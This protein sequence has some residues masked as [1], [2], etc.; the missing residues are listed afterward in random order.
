MAV[1]DLRHRHAGACTS[2]T[3]S[4]SAKLP[5][6]EARIVMLSRTQA[7]LLPLW[8]IAGLHLVP[9]LAQVPTQPMPIATPA[10]TGSRADPAD[11]RA[12]VPPALYVSPLRS[13]QAFTEASVAPWRETNERVRQ[14]GGWR[15]YARE[16]QQPAAAQPAAAGA[17]GAMPAAKPASGGHAGHEMK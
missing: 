12:P 16:A 7:A 17:S 10:A 1:R 5:A 2:M 4:G 15:A 14:R 9:A 11:A 3:A 13:Y 6:F 8:A